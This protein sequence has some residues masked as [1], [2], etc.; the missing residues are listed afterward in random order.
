MRTLSNP[1][2][3]YYRRK[4]CRACGSRRV[5]P[6]LDF[7]RMP[8]AGNFLLKSEV[9]HERA[10]PLRISL[11]H[12]C[13]LVQVLDVV[14]AKIVFGDYGYLSSVNSALRTPFERYAADL[15]RELRGV[16]DPVVVEI[17]GMAGGRVDPLQHRGIALLGLC[18]G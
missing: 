7:G 9:G 12:D 6:F 11:C 17:G 14:S 1:D 3:D 13:S 5:R 18:P 4:T 2:A 8:L 16:G 10:Y 15:A